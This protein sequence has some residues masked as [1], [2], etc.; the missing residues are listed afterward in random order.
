MVIFHSYVSLPE[1]N[2]EILGY[3]L[4]DL[5]NWKDHERS[6]IKIMGKSTTLMVILKI[7]ANCYSLLEGGFKHRNATRI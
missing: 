4:V 3:F 7:L 6:T 1:G 2:H 5:T